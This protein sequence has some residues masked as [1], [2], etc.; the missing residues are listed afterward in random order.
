MEFDKIKVSLFISTLVLLAVTIGMIVF[1]IK[2]GEQIRH[3]KSDLKSVQTELADKQAEQ[4]TNQSESEK[5]IKEFYKT[6]YNYEKSQKEISMTTVKELATDNVYQE[7]Q[8]EINVNNSYSPQQNTIQKSSV[9]ENEI[10][11][12]A[13]ESKDNTQQYLVTAPIYQVFNGTK[14]DFEINQLI[15]IKNQKI[16]QRTT[17]QLG[18]E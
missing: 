11:I 6:V 16:T 17:I 12:L 3:L 8:N 4:N 5:I 10:K 13:Y 7:L 14:N 18:E 1:G 9:N 15:Q 2:Q